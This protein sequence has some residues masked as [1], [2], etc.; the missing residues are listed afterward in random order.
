MARKVLFIV[1]NSDNSRCAGLLSRTS[2]M[3]LFW[4]VA[5]TSFF[6]TV[7]SVVQY[8]ELITSLDKT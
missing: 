5:R 8:L 6:L 4:L 3:L 7:T 1:V 2:A